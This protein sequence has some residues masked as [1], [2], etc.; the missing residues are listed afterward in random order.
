MTVAMPFHLSCSLQNNDLGRSEPELVQM[1][2]SN[3]N[4]CLKKERLPQQLHQRQSL[5]KALYVLMKTVMSP[6][7]I[8]PVLFYKPITLIWS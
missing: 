8:S 7:V 4:M 1:V 3:V 6:P 5:F 2:V